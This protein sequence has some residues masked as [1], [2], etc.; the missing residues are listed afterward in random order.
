[1]RVQAPYDWNEDEKIEMV[2]QM[3][4]QINIRGNIK[5]KE[6]TLENFMLIVEIKLRT[7]V[8]E[9]PLKNEIEDFFRI[10]CQQCNIDITQPNRIDVSIE[11]LPNT[12]SKYHLRLRSFTCIT[13]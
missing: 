13:Y 10:I 8:E 7:L 11:T 2:R 9:E 12:N 5:I 1:M 3:V 6:T 4:D